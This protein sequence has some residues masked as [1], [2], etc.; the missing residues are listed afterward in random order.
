MVVIHMQIDVIQEIRVEFHGVA[1]REKHHYLLAQ[2][3][4]QEREQEQ[5]PLF[6]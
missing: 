1:A 4:L 3:P 6:R 2:V 5:E